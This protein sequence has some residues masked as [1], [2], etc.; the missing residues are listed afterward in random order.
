MK[1]YLTFWQAERMA[2]VQSAIH[3]RVGEGDKVLVFARRR[4]K[5]LNF[6]ERWEMVYETTNSILVV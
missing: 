5:A 4:I 2:K 1:T 3:V 6:P